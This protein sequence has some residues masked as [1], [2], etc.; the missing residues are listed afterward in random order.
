MNFPLV[1]RPLA[2]IITC[3]LVLWISALACPLPGEEAGLPRE[4]VDEDDDGMDDNWER[5]HFGDLSNDGSADTD[6]DTMTDKLEH[7]AGTGP[8]TADTDG[9]GRPDWSGLKGY[10]YQEFW[11]E[12]D[13][14]NP[15]DHYPRHLFNAP[16]PEVSYHRGATVLGKDRRNFRQRLRGFLVAPE[17]GEYRFFIAGNSWCEIWLGENERP[18]SA[19][20]L[21]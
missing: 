1:P 9:D 2:P 19:K 11:D 18:E 5:L 16:D 21:A 10:L 15:R 3:S 20:R 12:S 13:G 7:D 4:L 17:S 6:G 8:L 14:P